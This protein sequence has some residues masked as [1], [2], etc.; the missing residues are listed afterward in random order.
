ML[1]AALM[2]GTAALPHVIVK[3]FTVPTVNDARLSAAWALIFL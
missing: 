1:T 3:F 2:L